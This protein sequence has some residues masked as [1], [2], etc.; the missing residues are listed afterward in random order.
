MLSAFIK[1]FRWLVALL[2]MLFS[3]HAPAFGQD[4]LSLS[5]GAECPQKDLPDVIRAVYCS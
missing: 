5:P 2:A 1:K 3:A 4:S